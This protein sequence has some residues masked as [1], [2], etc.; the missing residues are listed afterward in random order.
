MFS[1][2]TWFISFLIETAEKKLSK[3]DT[4]I[5]YTMVVLMSSIV[6]KGFTW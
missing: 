6:V 5:L 3:L 2:R 1:V 4:V